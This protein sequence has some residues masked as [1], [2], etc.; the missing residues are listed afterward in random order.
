MAADYLVIGAGA[1]GLAFTD[2]LVDHDPRARVTLVDR[3]DGVGGHWREAYPFVRL[4]Q[5]SP[6][7][8]V[9]STVLGG[10]RQTDGPEAG[11]LERAD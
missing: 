7:Y 11:L 10:D 1:S 3:R 2:A 9:A 6:F 4:H 5:A 8:G